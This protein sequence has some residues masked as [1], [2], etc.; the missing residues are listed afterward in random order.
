VAAPALAHSVT[1]PNG[2]SSAAPGVATIDEPT[3]AVAEEK[4]DAALSSGVASGPMSADGKRRKRQWF[5]EIF[6]DDYPR[7]TPRLPRSVIEREVKFIDESLGC[8]KGAEILDMGCGAGEHCVQLSTRGY[9]VIGLDLSLSMLARSADEAAE[10]SQK[11]NFVQADFRELNFEDAFDGIY[12]WGSTFGYFDDAKN[13][14]IIGRIF[15]ALRPHGRLL[16]DVPNRDFYVSRVPSMAWFE[17]EGCVCM[18]EAIHNA[19]NS[20]IHVKRTIMLDDGRKREFEY[21]MRLYSLHEL[22]KVLHDVG[23]RVVEVSG[24]TV[25]PSIFFE[26][27]SPRIIILVEK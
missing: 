22:G 8:A 18:D 11:I 21:S 16:L 12:V 15:R 7:T 24:E 14:E 25:T 26:S 19:I 3:I 4:H 27:E 6:N 13:S 23:F 20:R 17:G 5:E 2:Q 10:Y 1:L 9:N